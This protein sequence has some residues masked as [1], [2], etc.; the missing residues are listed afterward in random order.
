MSRSTFHSLDIKLPSS[1]E[2]STTVKNININ[3]GP[4]HPAAHGVLRLILQLS[5]EIIEKTD[6]HIGLLHRGSE[7]LAEDRYYLKS[8][9]YFDRFDYVSM[10]SQEHAYCLAIESI[11]GTT[12]INSMI[13]QVRTIYDELTRI[14][15]HMLAL[16]CHALDVGSMSSLFW[17]FEER[18]KIMEFYERA[19]GARM[20][21]AFYRPNDIN[22]ESINNTFIEDVLFFS[23]NC[24]VSINEMH[25]VLTFNKIW[26]QRLVNI[27]TFSYKTCLEYGLT[28]VLARSVGL[29]RDLRLSRLESY[30]SYPSINFRS[31]IGNKGD[32]YDRFLIRMYEMIES[33]NILNQVSKKFEFFNSNN[34][35]Y[36]KTYDNFNMTS[37][38]TK[39]IYNHNVTMENTIVDFKDWSENFELPSNMLS[40]SIESPKG[41]FG[42]CI[43][44]DNTN[45]PYRLK[46]RSPAYHSMQACPKLTKG[47]FLADLV[48]LIGTI[49]IVFGEIDR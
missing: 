23:K 20:H 10:L 41:E 36:N 16:S 29:K 3:F 9:P 43:L 24:L 13:C 17:A 11:L 21:A 47:H 6:P 4:Q 38:L 31:F 37:Y 39:K 5:G 28:G 12:N 14:L 18:E 35:D 19:S 46:V 22:Y 27:G 26:K 45:K 48:A 2:N 30:A 7:K 40:K 25:N 1:F 42:V 33:I 44:S 34:L 15:N 32:C 49:D 8:L